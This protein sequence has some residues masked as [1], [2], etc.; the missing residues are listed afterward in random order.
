[1][2]LSAAY[3][4]KQKEW[5]EEGRFERQQEMV[6]ALLQEGISPKRLPKRLVYRSRLF[7]SCEGD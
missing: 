5:K 6:I 3:I 7:K 1:M 4:Q 2:N